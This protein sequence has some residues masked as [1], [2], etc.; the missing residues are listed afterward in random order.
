MRLSF[1]CVFYYVTDL[2]R[3]IDFYADV[4]GMGLRS[5]DA[6]A[7][8][9]L[10]GVLI[11]LVPLPAGE[12]PIGKGNARLCLEVDDLDEAVRE[13]Q[14]RGVSTGEVKDAGNGML[15]FFEDPDSNE[16]CLWQ[17]LRDP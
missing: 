15:A 11:E 14:G 2:E 3:A 8:F 4:L 13:L 16:I 17:Y 1:D 5:R 10:D 6:V 7:R 9:E 12:K